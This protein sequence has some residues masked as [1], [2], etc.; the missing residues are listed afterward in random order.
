MPRPRICPIDKEREVK[1]IIPVFALISAAGAIILS[2][3]MKRLWAA[4]LLFIAFFCGLS[5][6]FWLTLWAFSLCAGKREYN[7][8][9]RLYLFLL[10]CAYSYVCGAARLKVRTK[11]LEML[12]DEPFLLVSNHLSNLDNMV[13]SLCLYPRP[14]AYIAKAELFKIPLVR[15]LITRCLYLSLDRKNPRKGRETIA[16]AMELIKTVP[17][18]VYPEGHRGNGTELGEF[19]AGCLKIATKTGSPI[20]VAVIYGTDKAKRRAPFRATEVRFEI[21]EV[22]TPGKRKTAELSG[23]ILE[24]LALR[25]ESLRKEGQE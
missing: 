7:A 22:I 16:K 13:Q 20:A 18:G 6:L 17:V 4:V 8:P 10:N 2:I 23:E 5:A 15:G 25:F 11:G 19:H 3:V 1:H 21:V 14:I 9:S 24:K 12:P